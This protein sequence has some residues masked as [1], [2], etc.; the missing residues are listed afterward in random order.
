MAVDRKGTLQAAIGANQ[1]TIQGIERVTR[2]Y[3]RKGDEHT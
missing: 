3:D 2:D 1:Y